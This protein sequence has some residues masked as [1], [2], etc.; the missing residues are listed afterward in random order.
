MVENLLRVLAQN[1]GRRQFVVPLGFQ[2]RLICGLRGTI[3]KNDL[4]LGAPIITL[5]LLAYI[6][7]FRCG[8]AERSC[9]TNFMFFPFCRC[10]L[11]FSFT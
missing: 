1:Q 3:K 8:R 9:L 7:I 10:R 6:F 5:T 2:V 4:D 11:V